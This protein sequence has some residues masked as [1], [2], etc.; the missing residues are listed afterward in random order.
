[1]SPNDKKTIRR[2]LKMSKKTRIIMYSLLVAMLIFA[3]FS[4]VYKNNKQTDLSANPQPQIESNI[5]AVDG[6]T[7]EL[8]EVTSN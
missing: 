1:M 3:G 5:D 7:P 2:I 4:V 8:E 6:S